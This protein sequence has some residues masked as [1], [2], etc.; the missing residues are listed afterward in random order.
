MMKIGNFPRTL[1]FCLMLAAIGWS[2]PGAALAATPG[3]AGKK[4]PGA[5]KT[6]TQG[7][8]LP[9]FGKYRV[10]RIDSDG[11]FPRVL[12]IDRGSTVI[13]F[14]ATGGYSSVV[15]SK[16]EAL[17]RATRSPTLFFLAPDGTYVSAAFGPGASA[18][19]A[20]IQAGRYFYFVT[21]LSVSEG[22]AFAQVVVK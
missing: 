15:F 8:Q 1:V 10:V 4:S 22:G 12:R 16:G 5:G 14:N 3:G 11:I 2:A 21:G 18:S 6:G 9:G 7:K 17:N 13:W 20:F 19:A